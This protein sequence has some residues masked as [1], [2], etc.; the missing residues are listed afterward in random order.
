MG[1]SVRK[2]DGTL[3][4]FNIQKVITAIGKSAERVIVTFTDEDITKICCRYFNHAF[5]CGKRIGRN[6]TRSS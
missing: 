3:E 5:H 1:Y 4:P 2:K 6:K